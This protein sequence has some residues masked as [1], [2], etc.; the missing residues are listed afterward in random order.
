MAGHSVSR[1]RRRPTG[2]R[3]GIANDQLGGQ[4]EH[5]ASGRERP[6]RYPTCRFLGRQICWEA[7]RRSPP[8][9]AGSPSTYYEMLAC[10]FDPLSGEW[11]G[12]V[13]QC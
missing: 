7:I 13:P 5:D 12:E 11:T 1:E 9:L 6:R 10:G 4:I 3:S 2:T 8:V